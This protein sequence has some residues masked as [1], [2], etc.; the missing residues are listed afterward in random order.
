M[1]SVMGHSWCQVGSGC[2]RADRSSTDARSRPFWGH[3]VL[4]WWLGLLSVTAPV[5]LASAQS[6]GAYPAQSSPSTQPYYP[7]QYTVPQQQT[8]P[9]QQPA[10]SPPPQRFNQPS[11]TYAPVP[12]R[13]PNPYRP[14][15]PRQPYPSAQ[16]ARGYYYPQ[17]APVQPRA[18]TSAAAPPRPSAPPWPY[19]GG[20]PPVIP[21]REGQPVPPGYRLESSGGGGL[22]AAGL[23][24]GGTVYGAGLVVAANAGFKN[25]TGWL[26][27]PIIGPWVAIGAR[28]IPCTSQTVN[29]ACIDAAGDELRA[30][31]YLT[32][33]GL[34]QA[35]GL[36][37]LLAGG[38]ARQQQLV[39]NDIASVKLVP[40]YGRNDFG[41]DAVGTF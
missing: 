14:A 27:L 22:I 12:A 18:Q 37:L 40:R 35:I 9:Y 3:A 38:S 25:G 28:K 41:L 17:R 36:T 32:A 33:D 29:L 21:Y 10:Q 6:T 1:A 7:Q 24:M 30:V 34:F 26:V 2:R 15:Q 19:S 5:A 4:G 16:P 8:S 23:V 11:P 31:A 39:R 20:L 13:Q